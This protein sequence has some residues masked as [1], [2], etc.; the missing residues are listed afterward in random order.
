MSF[1]PTC[2]NLLLVQQSGAG[3]RL[4]CKTCPYVHHITKTITSKVELKRKEVED[5]LGGAD[6]WK[7]ASETEVTCPKCGHKKAYFQ[8]IQTRSADEPMTQFYKCSNM[9]CG[10]QWKD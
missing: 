4:Y 2:A 9:S 10:A 5:V 3:F 8:Q 7:H 6:A 1:C